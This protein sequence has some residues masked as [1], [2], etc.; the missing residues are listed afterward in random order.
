MS[1]WKNPKR[2][3]FGKW[4]DSKGV[5]Q[6]DFADESSVSRRTIWRVCNEKDY[7]PS[8]SVLK[9]IMKTVRTIDKNKK[10]ND[11]FDL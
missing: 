2:S 5:T 7:I 8:T 9:K 3:K 1:W 6:I 11:F 4:L 10:T